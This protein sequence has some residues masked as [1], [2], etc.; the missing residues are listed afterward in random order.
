MSRIQKAIIHARENADK[1]KRPRKMRPMARESTLPREESTAAIHNPLV[2]SAAPRVDVDAEVFRANRILTRQNDDIHPAESA[3][4]MLRTRVMRTMRGNGWQILGVSSISP[5]EGKTF[6][7]INLAISIAAEVDQEAIL[8]DLDL[9]RPSV[10]EFLGIDPNDFNDLKDYIENDR[11]DL[12]DFLICPDIDRLGCIVSAN[13]LDRPS[14]VLASTRGKLFF[15]ELRQ[16]IAP[17]VV[18]VIDLP[19]LL[20]AD[21]ALA[22]APML[23]AFLLVVAEGSAERADLAEIRPFLHDF[24]HIGTVLNKSVERDTKRSG[25]Y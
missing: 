1:K 12:R 22:V 16:R 21:D 18:V 7:A 13:A 23:D 9:H 11:Q 14:D 24:N 20:S 10:Y 6:T 5:D 25:Y 15:Q 19:P 2:P 3:Y 4:R 8:I 17:E